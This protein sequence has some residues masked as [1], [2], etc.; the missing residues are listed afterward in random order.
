MDFPVGSL[1]VEN[2]LEFDK[3]GGQE[4]TVKGRGA[5]HGRLKVERV[6]PPEDEVLGDLLRFS[7]FKEQFNK[8]LWQCNG[9]C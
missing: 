1:A 6:G 3:R 4:E 7:C 5:S 8:R 9:S 2:P